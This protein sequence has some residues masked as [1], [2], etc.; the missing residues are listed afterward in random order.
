MS[1]SFRKVQRFT[2]NH[3]SQ[4]AYFPFKQNFYYNNQMLQSR[5][6]KVHVDPIEFNATGCRILY[7]F[8]QV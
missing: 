1:P 3:T 2:L 5:E 7:V 8:S 6:T 4:S